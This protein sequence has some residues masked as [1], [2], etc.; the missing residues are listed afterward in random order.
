MQPTDLEIKGKALSF[1]V[2]AIRPETLNVD[3]LLASAR[4]IEAY[5]RDVPI[6]AH[7]EPVV[8][9]ESEMT[10]EERQML[11]LGIDHRPLG[12]F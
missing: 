10:D 8:T 6:S 3:A 2:A 1:A 9:V 12:G 4:A 5:I 7:P 11:G